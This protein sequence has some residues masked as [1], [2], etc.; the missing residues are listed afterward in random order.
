MKRFARKLT[1]RFYITFGQVSLLMSLLLLAIHLEFVPDRLSAVRT[2]RAALAEAVAANGSVSISATDIPRLQA[3]LGFVV[4][5]NA[6]LLSAAVRKADGEVIA[7][8][9]DHEQHWRALP[10]E[11]S[12]DSEVQV[13]IWAGDHKWGQVELRFRP[14]R[15]PGWRG[16]VEDERTWLAVFMTLSSF[17]L[18]YF[19]LGRM[20]KYLDPSGVIPEKVKSAFDAMAEGLLVTDDKGHIHLANQAFATVIGRPPKELLG[21]HPSDFTWCTSDGT[22]FAETEKETYPWA[23]ALRE[24]VPQRNITI[25]LQDGAITRRSF[26]VNCAPI[27][28]AEGQCAALLISF[29]DITQLEEKETELR[30]AKEEADAA[31]QAKSHFLASMSHE[32]RTPLNAVLGFTELLR[33]GYHRSENELKRHLDTIYASGKHLLELINDI[34]DLSKVEAGRLELER[35]RCAPYPIIQE[36]VRV[37]EVKATEKGISLDLESDGAIP[38]T[39]QTDPAR[40]RQI[41]TNLLGNAIKFTETGGVKVKVRLTSIEQ[42]SQLVIAVADTGIGIPEDKLETVFEPFAQADISVAQKFGGTGLGLAISR[43]LAHALGGDIS[44]RSEEGKGSVFTLVLDIGPLADLRLVVPDGVV[45]QDRTAA[46]APASWVFPPARILV[47]DDG[48]ENRELI[49]LVLEQTGL[50]VEEAE[51]GSVALEKALQQAFAL[52]LMDIQMP[53]MDGQTATRLLR[54]RG[55]KVPIIALTAHAMKG[56]EQALLE[57]GCSGYL[58]KPIEIDKL[59][60]SLADWL[61]GHPAPGSEGGDLSA[62]AIGN[63]EATSERAEDEPIVSRLADHPRLRGVVRKF[64][65]RLKDQLAAIEQA[66]QARDF[67]NLASLAHWLKGAGGTVGFDVFTEPALNLEQLAKARR[68]EQIAAAITVLNRLAARIVVPSDAELAKSKPGSGSGNEKH[69]VAPVRRRHSAT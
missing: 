58:T 8:V 50:Q 61:G 19:Y 42:Q 16:I 3:I 45:A 34:L 25:C 59:L 52:I 20:L 36:V 28:V 32:I 41:L 56:F 64:A 38:E 29:D 13:P 54:H 7:T 22:P 51:N 31:S 65:H 44:V 47:V 15:S 62:M 30:K 27:M 10:R 63:E 5:R 18:F 40:L 68:G 2:G 39:I 69:E 11:Y 33:R 26:M 67:D 57:A 23:R 48:E 1:A 9:G 49:R 6:D 21:R 35:I 46:A 4:E 37:L 43:R 53:V 14:L 60:H 55:V 17:A 66:W 12:T 24:Q